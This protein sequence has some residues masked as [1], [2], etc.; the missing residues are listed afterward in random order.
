M[1]NE[2][3]IILPN[4]NSAK[5]ISETINSVINQSFKKWKLIIVDDASKDGAKNILSKF[6]NDK[7]IKIYWLKKNKGAG[8]CRNYAIKKSNSKYVAFIDSDD[9]WKKNK[10]KL[11]LEFMKKNKYNFTYTFYETFGLKIRKIKTPLKFNFVGFVKNTSIGTST[12]MILRKD[13]KKIR[14]ASEGICEDYT[15]KCDLLRK[16]GFAYCLN[17]YLTKYRV[18]S[19]SLQSSKIR[20]LYW[21]WKINSNV[22]KLGFW[23]NF[24]SLI[25]I[26]INSFT[27]YGFK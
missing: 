2:I 7:R 23:E 20:N 6:K 5:Y 12:M 10:L 26:S 11:Q 25:S 21:I 19:N 16:V 24:N 9:V 15:F 27:K 13:I 22:N 4:F 14:F 8:F 3:D 18:R 17:K 1:K